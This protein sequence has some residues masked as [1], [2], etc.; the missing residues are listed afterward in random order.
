MIGYVLLDWFF[1]LFHFAII[2]FNQFGWIWKKSR[3]WNLYLLLITGFFW[4]GF[5]FFYG[6][7]YCPLTDWH[8]QVLGRLGKSP[9]E[10]SY[11]TYIITRFFGLHLKASIVDAVTL[12]CYLSALFIS[13]FLNLRNK[14]KIS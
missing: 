10:Y 12:I 6:W 1:I 3:R 13:I 4:F 5:G 9:S 14:R 7:G 2:L 8:F 11:I